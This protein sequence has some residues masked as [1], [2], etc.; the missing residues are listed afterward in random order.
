MEQ[1]VGAESS[2]ENNLNSMNIGMPMPVTSSIDPSG[3]T[4]SS[5]VVS[6][7][8]SVPT[9][10]TSQQQQQA[11]AAQS[12]HIQL[13][14]GAMSIGSIAMAMGL[15]G[16]NTDPN[17]L[18]F[19]SNALATLTARMGMSSVAGSNSTGLV[20]PANSL[21]TFPTN[22]ALNL[23]PGVGMNLPG[24]TG[25]GVSI[26]DGGGLSMAV[27]GGMAVHA[28]GNV[29]VVGVAASNDLNSNVISASGQQSQQQQQQGQHNGGALLH[30]NNVHLNAG[31][32]N[33][34]M[35]NNNNNLNANAQV[36]RPA[37]AQSVPGGSNSNGGGG[38][39][40]IHGSCCGGCKT[41]VTVK[42]QFCQTDLSTVLQV[43]FL[44][45]CKLRL[46]HF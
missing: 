16:A 3:N 7:S 14:G 41:R 42:D 11:L 40:H 33:M 34:N 8:I 6:G 36:G 43:S 26:V 12:Q 27:A 1:S 22:T 46:I 29:N 19:T 45:S 4:P 9:D 17:S 13:P 25:T 30:N 21:V 37:G 5:G 2:A 31:G 18:T 20:G 28:P 24:A 39:G 35:V 44:R 32:N 23:V 38:Q 15:S 10:S